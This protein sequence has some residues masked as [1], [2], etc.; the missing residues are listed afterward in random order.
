MYI[1]IYMYPAD[2]HRCFRCQVTAHFKN[3]MFGTGQIREM[4]AA[5]T[6]HHFDSHLEGMMA[7]ID[8][9]KTHLERVDLGRE[10]SQ[11]SIVLA[12]RSDIISL[13]GDKDGRYWP[14]EI[15]TPCGDDYHSRET[16]QHDCTHR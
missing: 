12:V 15:V 6:H 14:V 2:P 11:L 5:C 3:W 13:H 9:L 10:N 16:W 4:I 8:F 7:R 1:C